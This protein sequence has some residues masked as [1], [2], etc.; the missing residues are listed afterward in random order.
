VFLLDRLGQAAYGTWV[1]DVEGGVIDGDG[2][3]AGF[4]A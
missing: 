1:G 3:G 2:G 4:E